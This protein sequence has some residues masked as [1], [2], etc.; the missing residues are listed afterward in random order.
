MSMTDSDD[1]YINL[2]YIAREF[3]EIAALKQWQSY[4]TPK[5]LAS[6]AVVEASELLAEFQWLTAEQSYHLSA[7]KKQAVAH[8]MA[9]V[10]MYLS[11]L[12][13]Q[14]DIDMMQ[15]IQSKIEFNKK[16]FSSQDFTGTGSGE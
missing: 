2:S 15:A 10:M 8:E 16:R 4:H 5:N 3:C 6:A 9:D 14:L 13:Q 7:A 1:I 11:M 12:C